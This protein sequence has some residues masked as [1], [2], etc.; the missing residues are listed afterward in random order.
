MEINKEESKSVFG[1][2]FG[3]AKFEICGLEV[4]NVYLYI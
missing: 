4:F 2:E 3:C 1:V